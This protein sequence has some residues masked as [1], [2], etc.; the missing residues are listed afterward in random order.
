M[1]LAHES[2]EGTRTEKRGK[3]RKTDDEYGVSFRRFACLACSGRKARV[4][5]SAAGPAP[6]STGAGAQRAQGVLQRAPQGAR[7]DGLPPSTQTRPTHRQEAH[8]GRD[9]HFDDEGPRDTS[10]S[11]GLT[12]LQGRLQG[13]NT[14]CRTRYSLKR[15]NPAGETG[16]AHGT[17]PRAHQ[18]PRTDATVPALARAQTSTWRS[19][20]SS[21]SPPCALSSRPP[22]LPY[23]ASRC[24]H[25]FAPRAPVASSSPIHHHLWA[26]RPLSIAASLY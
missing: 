20:L 3:K 9:E 16:A 13:R 15:T 8:A 11:S 22:L 26:L 25:S 1:V 6:A 19:T 4:A 2:R 5:R 21:R 18:P 23:A 10:L 17:R 7:E 12:P 24:R 14:A